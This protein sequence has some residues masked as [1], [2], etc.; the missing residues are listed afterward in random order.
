MLGRELGRGRVDLHA[1]HRIDLH[2][3]WVLQE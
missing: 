2:R 3:H 1:A